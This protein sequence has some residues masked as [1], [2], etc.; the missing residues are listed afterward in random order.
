VT[1]APVGDFV[2]SFQQILRTN[3]HRRRRSCVKQIQTNSSNYA[4]VIV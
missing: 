2:P 1:I 3:G 4:H